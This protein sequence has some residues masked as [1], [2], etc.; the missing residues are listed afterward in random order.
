VVGVI[1]LSANIS[2]R[3]RRIPQIV[4]AL[5]RVNLREHFFVRVA[6]LYSD[7]MGDNFISRRFKGILPDM[8]SQR[9]RDTKFPLVGVVTVPVDSGII[10]H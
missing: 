5:I 3:Y 4:S 9:C 2:R 8:I 7:L 10:S 6:D 1:N